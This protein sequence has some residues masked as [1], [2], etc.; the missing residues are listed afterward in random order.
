[1]TLYTITHAAPASEDLDALLDIC[2][3][4]GRLARTA[5][6][7]RENNHPIADYSCHATNADGL[8]GAISFWP[9][10]IGQA[11]TE[12]LG[13]LLGPLAVHPDM[14]G[15]GLGLALMQEALASIDPTRFAFVLLVGDLPYYE[16]AGFA[17]APSAVRLPGP[18]DPQR[19]LVR[20]SDL[21]QADICTALGGPVRPAPEMC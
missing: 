13:L 2:F 17:V 5:E 12:A 8:M 16:R 10:A 4:P 21:S 20:P 1:M 14:R 15:Q 9:I 19:L 6:R 18:V 11:D 7:L 3:G